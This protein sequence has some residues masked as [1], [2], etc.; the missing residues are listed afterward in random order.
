M[1]GALPK[2]YL[3]LI[4]GLAGMTSAKAEL[5]RM[6]DGL[7]VV[8]SALQINAQ[9][10]KSGAN[11][12]DCGG[13]VV[14]SSK[15]SQC[16][17]DDEKTQ[18]IHVPMRHYRP[19]TENSKTVTKAIAES[20]LRIA[21]FLSAH[22]NAEVFEEGTAID[23][24]SWFGRLLQRMSDAPSF[25]CASDT[26]QA[27]FP[28]GIPA[29]IEDTNEAQQE[30]L[31]FC[32]GARLLEA[33]GRLKQIHQ[34]EDAWLNIK[35]NQK[36]ESKLQSNPNDARIFSDPELRSLAFDQREKFLVKKVREYLADHPKAQVV[37]L[38][39]KVHDYSK[40]FTDLRFARAEGCV[41]PDPLAPVPS[42]LRSVSGNFLR[43]L[44]S[45]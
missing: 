35:M 14:M 2:I 11:K 43:N 40:Y 39:G 44:K 34:G 15:A 13:A 23:G 19:E 28:R 8:S 18:V 21:Q 9:V 41:P 32:G 5:L 12:P 36:L 45:R 33:F 29:K 3:F 17:V 25:K 10:S 24:S 1:T 42:T 26:L 27:M 31:S 30:L 16:H 4:A 7:S 37:I 20:Q 22:P 38:F 6:D